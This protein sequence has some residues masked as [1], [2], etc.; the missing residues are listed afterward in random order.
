MKR[1]KLAAAFFLIFISFVLCGELYQK[2]LGTYTNQFNYFD[3]SCEDADERKEALELLKKLSAQ[4]NTQIFM[5]SKK[6]AD[7]YSY[8]ETIYCSDETRSKLKKGYDVRE[9]GFNSLFSGN[10]DITIENFEAAAENLN[11]E[12][13]Y[14]IGSYKDVQI[15]KELF[16]NSFG[17]SYVHKEATSSY[18]WLVAC[19]WAIIGVLITML[20]WLDIQFQKK[21]NFVLISLGVSRSRIIIKN[22][23]IDFSAYLIMYSV[24]FFAL[25]NY[26]YLGY[27]LAVTLPVFA[28]FVILSSLLYLSLY[29]IDYKQAL[30]GA[31][32]NESTVSNCYLLKAIT[33]IVTVVVLSSNIILIASNYKSFSQLKSLEQFVDYSFLSLNKYNL[34][35]FDAEDSEYQ[36]S[37]T[38]QIY[39]DYYKQNKVASAESILSTAEWDC[40]LI[41]NNSFSLISDIVDIKLP[42]LNKDCYIFMPQNCKDKEKAE[43]LI[44][45]IIHSNFGE[46]EGASF[47]TVTYN[48]N[49]EVLSIKASETPGSLGFEPHKNPII[50]YCNFSPEV[51]KGFGDNLLSTGIS[52][53]DI[54]FKMEESDLNELEQKYN[55]EE[56]GYY[57]SQQRVS[58]RFGRFEASL[59]RIILLNSIISVLMLALEITVVSTLIKMEYKA[60][61]MELAVKK[62]LGYSI[63]QK[64]KLLFLLNTYA[65]VI[66]IATVIT[67]SLMFGFSLWYIV[68]FAGL[69]LLAF[70]Y[71]IIT[72][73]ILKFE[74]TNISKILK[75]GSL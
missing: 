35:S 17:S 3:I 6:T 62:T 1:I 2:Y 49:E 20:T 41:N 60:H 19:I 59:V 22:I 39:A 16:N 44:K 31:N 30:Y 15:I 24:L 54:M 8:S 27:R 51:L 63:Y 50:V 5:A 25:K 7:A 9:G 34:S 36:S 10:T 55:A 66:G 40:C 65:A 26:T 57:F 73:N 37:V 48:S 13:C 64:N 45:N 23:I 47:E 67:I 21:E 11:A 38:K 74:K 53:S 75:G 58:D 46:L 18:H 28:A 4:Y 68:L 29:K 61:S 43:E 14:F 69:F 33:M 52:F 72:L 12:R 71:L 42:D 70:E 56:H 32:I